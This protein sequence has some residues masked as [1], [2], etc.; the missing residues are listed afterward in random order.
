MLTADEAADIASEAGLGIADAAALM[1][2]ADSPDEARSIAKKFA[3]SEEQKFAAQLFDG[4][5]RIDV[6]PDTT[7]DQLRQ[8]FD[9]K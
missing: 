9:P 4:A 7:N 8:L 1:R 6:T 3:G 5:K 2:L